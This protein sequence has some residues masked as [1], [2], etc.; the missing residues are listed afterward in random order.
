MI[1]ELLF[2]SSFSYYLATKKSLLQL[3]PLV[4][5]ASKDLS[6]KSLIF[7]VTAGISINEIIKFKK[8]LNNKITES[9]DI[10]SDL[11]NNIGNESNKFNGFIINDSVIISL[12]TGLELTDNEV[13]EIT[14]NKKWNLVA[15]KTIDDYYIGLD[16]LGR[17]NTT[18]KE[19][20]E[21]NDL[22]LELIY[23]IEY[24]RFNG[25]YIKI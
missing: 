25:K 16:L 15:F 20:I 4:F 17:Q 6:K 14:K 5:L 10:I 24:L 12:D 18:F 23:K 8:E 13:L 7:G 3:F 11:G 21:K 1:L 9:K 22:R 2:S 19:Y